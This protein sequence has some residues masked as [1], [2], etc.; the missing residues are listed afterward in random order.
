MCLYAIWTNRKK[1][2]SYTLETQLHEL[3]LRQGVD[4]ENEMET[5]K[6]DNVIGKNTKCEI[7]N[8]SS[9]LFH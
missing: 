2:R 3:Y 5:Q 7:K 4:S 6:K 1:E 9:K 8:E